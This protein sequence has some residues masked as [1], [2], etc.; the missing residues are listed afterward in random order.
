MKLLK[1]ADPTAQ[2][3]IKKYMKLSHQNIVRYFDHFDHEIHDETYTCIVFEYCQVKK[4]SLHRFPFT[5]LTQTHQNRSLRKQIEKAPKSA[6]KKIAQEKIAKW[7]F[8]ASNGLSFLHSEKIVHRDI[9]PEY[10]KNYFLTWPSSRFLKFFFSFD[11]LETCFLQIE[12]LSKLPT[13]V[14]RFLGKS[15]RET[16]PGPLSTRAQSTIS[17]PR[18]MKTTPTQPTCGQLNDFDRFIC[19][20]FLDRVF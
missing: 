16:R 9:K 13:W 3:E 7:M 17:A 18:T 10:S 8:E 20:L 11:S 14:C 6:E 15:P 5:W 4:R 19:W 12:R 2:N 1:Q